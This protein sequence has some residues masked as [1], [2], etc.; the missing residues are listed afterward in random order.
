MRVVLLLPE[1]GSIAV[2]AGY[3]PEDTLDEADLAAAKW[4]FENNRPAGRG[5][6]TL[7]GAKRLFLPHA[8]R[9]RRVGVVGLDSDKP[10]PAAD[11]RAAA[12]ASTRSSDQAAL[13]IERVHLVEDVER[14]KLRRRDRPAALGAADLD[15]ARS[16]RRRSPP[17]SA[18]P[19]R[20]GTSPTALD[21]AG[22][23]RAARDHHRRVRAAQPLHRQPA[24]HDPARVRRGR[25]ERWP[26]TTSARSSARALQRGEQDPGR[27]PG[28]GRPRRRPADAAARRGPVR[29]GPVQPARQRRQVCARGLDDPH[30]GLA[31]PADAI[32]LQVLDEGE[33]IPPEDLE[34]IFDKF[35]RAQKGDR[36][37]AGTGL[38]LAI[39]RGFVEAMGGTIAA[40]NRSDRSGAVFTITLPVPAGR[41]TTGTSAA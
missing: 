11:A 39:S 15:L 20:C 9:A 13:A 8:H 29:A 3:P 1:S 32:C 7:P 35:Y 31:R 12:A 22:Q 19:A 24:R 25:A 18:R 4:A 37:R 41:R 33:G 16:A 30:P 21:E 2:Q 23:G 40:A 5:A 6:D 26:C 36:V 10:G 27:A 28:R 17:S 34:R 14:A 38:G